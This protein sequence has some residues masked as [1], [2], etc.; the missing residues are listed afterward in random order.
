VLRNG[1]LNYKEF[2]INGLISY[3]MDNDSLFMSKEELKENWTDAD[4]TTD[5]TDENYLYERKFKMAVLDWL[6]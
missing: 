1:V 5:L 4:A 3:L 2:P 6:N